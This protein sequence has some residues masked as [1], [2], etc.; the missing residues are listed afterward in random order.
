MVF[1]AMAVGAGSGY[2]IPQIQGV[3]ENVGGT[4]SFIGSP[5]VTELGEDNAAWGVAVEADD[6]NDALVIKVTGAS[7]VWIRWVAS[8][9][10]VEVS[11]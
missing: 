9:R 4:T 10:T 8:V 1:S 3:I 5:T 6:G 11:W 7:A 2:A